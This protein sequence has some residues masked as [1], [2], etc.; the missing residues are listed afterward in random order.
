VGPSRGAQGERNWD[1]FSAYESGK[2]RRYGL[3]FAANGGAFALIGFLA[4]DAR[5]L[6]AP[7]IAFWAFIIIPA[8][9]L[10]FSWKMC[11]D[12]FTF[13]TMMREWD[14]RLFGKEGQSLLAYIRW[15]FIVG[16]VSAIV[17]AITSAAWVRSPPSV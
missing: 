11:N 9:M 5:M 8:L 13:G 2:N 1:I 14:Q 7:P 6:V 10:V 15:L 3:L 4:G 12:I 17:A 16:W